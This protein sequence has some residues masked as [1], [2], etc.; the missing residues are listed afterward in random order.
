M[1]R[2]TNKA[3]ANDA[4]R[5]CMCGPDTHRVRQFQLKELGPMDVAAERVYKGEIGAIVRPPATQTYAWGTPPACTQHMRRERES[6]TETHNAIERERDLHGWLG[7]W[8]HC[9]WANACVWVGVGGSVGPLGARRTTSRI[10]TM[11]S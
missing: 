1:G 5:V 4:V 11:Q 6:A 9:L 10:L 8:A 2:E 7:V 3:R